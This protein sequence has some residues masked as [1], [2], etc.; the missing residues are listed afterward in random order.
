MEKKTSTLTTLISLSGVLLMLSCF[1]TSNDEEDNPTDVPEEEDI[2]QND[3][4]SNLPE[5]IDETANTTESGIDSMFSLLL[6][7]VE[8]IDSTESTQDFYGIEFE[9]L[10][11]G[12]G[13]AVVNNSSHIKA[14]FGFIVSSMLSLNSNT[15]IQKVIDSIET[16]INDADEYYNDDYT[17]SPGTIPEPETVAKTRASDPVS[18]LSSGLLNEAYNS[19][20]IN[21]VGKTLL[22]ESPKIML[23]QANPPS[24]PRFLTVSYI[25]DILTNDVIPR[26]NEVLAAARRLTN[27][28]TMSL[29]VTLY[30]ETTDIDKGDLYIFEGGVRLTRAMLSFLCIYD[31]DLHSPEGYKDMRWIE[32]LM[33]KSSNTEYSYKKIY[34]LSEDTLY[35]TWTNDLRDFSGEFSDIIAYNLNRDGF[36]EMKNNYFQSIYS[37]LKAAPEAIKKGLTSIRAEEDNQDNDLL[38]RSNI[39]D[40]DADMASFK[41]RMIDNGMSQDL[42]DKISTPEDL[43][44]FSEEILSQPYHFNE[45]LD[46]VDVN[47]TID[48]SK[49]FTNP[50]VDLKERMPKY[51]I[52]SG[53]DRITSSKHISS[54]SIWSAPKNTF[55]SYTSEQEQAIID[56]PDSEIDTVYDNID[57]IEVVLNSDYIVETQI[58]STISCVPIKYVDNNNNIIE[59]NLRNT[60]NPDSS[61]LDK[62]LPYFEDYTHGGVFPDMNTRQDWIDFLTPIAKYGDEL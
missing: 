20:G 59:D 33:E 52:V 50:P 60:T 47:I 17:D 23:A 5:D 18:S 39:L 48:L 31:Y 15:S 11:K 57:N 55:Y 4:P 25:Q 38:V 28:N 56:I 14:N 13:A 46:S 40:V 19:S 53:D 1:P 6:K 61:F 35:C 26:L 9:S 49:F 24:F 34:R 30:G 12:F 29:P 54:Y 44:D 42:A 36:L 2:T 45:T 37:D 51:K 43:M 27:L 3:D 32:D 58:D 16:Y 22:A 41:D 10:R 7:R 21:G 62:Y 8:K